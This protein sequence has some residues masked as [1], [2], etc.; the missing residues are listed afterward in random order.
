M[1]IGAKQIQIAKQNVVT[2]ESKTFF[3]QETDSDPEVH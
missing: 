2:D 1:V 3:I